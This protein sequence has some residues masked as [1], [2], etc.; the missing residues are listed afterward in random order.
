MKKV[1]ITD[2]KYPWRPVTEQ[3]VEIVEGK[4]F[5]WA[6]GHRRYLLGSS[7]FFIRSGAERR[8]INLLEQIVASSYMRNM[9][10]YRWQKALSA[11]QIKEA[12]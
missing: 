5:V 9:Q 6:K 11:L 8:R 4:K 12:A 7:A 1:F 10:S 2:L 3:E